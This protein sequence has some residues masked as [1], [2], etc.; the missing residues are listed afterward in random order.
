MRA[1]YLFHRWESETQRKDTKDWL[2]VLGSWVNDREA[3]LGPSKPLGARSGVAGQER[4]AFKNCLLQ[5][6]AGVSGQLGVGTG[7]SPCHC[8]PIPIQGPAG[9]E[10]RSQ[11]PQ[12]CRDRGPGPP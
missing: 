12:L 10:G 5:S 9:N 7:V 11:G 1:P 8:A 2:P 6:V 4:A 3:G